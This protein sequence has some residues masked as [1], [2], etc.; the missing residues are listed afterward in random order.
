MMRKSSSLKADIEKIKKLRALQQKATDKLNKITEKAAAGTRKKKKSRPALKTRPKPVKKESLWRKLA[1]K[2]GPA[3]KKKTPLKA[4]K[5]KKV[6]RPVS[7]ST[8]GEG[9]LF[10]HLR[11]QRR[12][13]R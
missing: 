13:K 10:H 8:P 3:P 1:G 4:V 7:R 2:K 6:K 11:A 9:F 12:G 5:K